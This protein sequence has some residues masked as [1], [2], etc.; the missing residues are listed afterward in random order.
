M[1]MTLIA[2][3]VVGSGGIQEVTFANIPQ[4]GK[5]LLVKASFRGEYA[6]TNIPLIMRIN[7][8]TGANYPYKNLRA[9]QSLVQTFGS[10]GNA[11]SVQA[12]FG[13]GSSAASGA[14]ATSDIYIY[15]YTRTG[16]KVCSI[17]NN[18]SPNNTTQYAWWCYLGSD[19]LTNAGAVTELDFASNYGD[20]LAQYSY[21]S[22]YIIS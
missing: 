19:A 5:D 1:T 22:L 9:S 12:G 16:T 20:D 10:S 14:F 7:N 11:S 2:T 4:T 18:L 6:D 13:S 17:Q 8:N 3:A 15:D 21:F